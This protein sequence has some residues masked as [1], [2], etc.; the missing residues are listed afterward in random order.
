MKN[1][2]LSE[3]EVIAGGYLRLT[4]F[5]AFSRTIQNQFKGGILHVIPSVPE[6]KEKIFPAA[7]SVRD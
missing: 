6:R 7:R 4:E 1:L 2:E 5:A 3:I